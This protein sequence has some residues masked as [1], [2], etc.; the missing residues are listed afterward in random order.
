MQS[1]GSSAGSARKQ[2]NAGNRTT[3]KR[4]PG[5]P[6]FVLLET[7]CGAGRSTELN[8]DQRRR[9]IQKLFNLAGHRNTPQSEAAQARKKGRQLMLELKSPDAAAPPIARKWRTEG[10]LYIGRRVVRE[11]KDDD[12]TQYDGEGV[13][14]GWV[15]AEESEFE[16]D[17]GNPAALWQVDYEDDHKGDDALGTEELEL[18]EVRNASPARSTWFVCIMTHPLGPLP[19]AR[20]PHR[21]RTQVVE[22]KG[23][24]S[25]SGSAREELAGAFGRGK[26]LYEDA[27]AAC[28]RRLD[29]S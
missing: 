16:D 17:N 3:G 21:A 12:G 13:L 4:E 20:R 18:A 24:R 7:E 2:D 8:H 1:R 14:T 19:G 9:K 15:P 27:R 29:H 25:W 6:D 22:R 23:R 10:S 11:V 26:G 5:E 28:A